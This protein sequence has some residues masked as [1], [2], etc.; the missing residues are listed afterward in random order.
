MYFFSAGTSWSAATYESAECAGV[1]IF[2]RQPVISETFCPP[3]VSQFIHSW[4]FISLQLVQIY[5]Q[6]LIFVAT[7]YVYKHSSVILMSHLLA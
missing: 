1:S 4:L 3:F 2:F 6:N 7:N 5:D